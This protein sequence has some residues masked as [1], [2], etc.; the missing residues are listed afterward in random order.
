MG[1]PT[2][3]ALHQVSLAL[4]AAAPP[5]LAAVTSGLFGYLLVRSTRRTVALAGGAGGA[6]VFGI[7]YGS[8]F[9]R[10]AATAVFFALLASLIGE[11]TVFAAA[12]F[13]LAVLAEPTMSL[14]RLARP[15]RP[16]GGR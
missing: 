16:R 10:M 4:S 15:R 12:G 2:G 11:R 14:F 1:S 9:L 3:Y 7:L 5:T 6:S 8:F 13:A